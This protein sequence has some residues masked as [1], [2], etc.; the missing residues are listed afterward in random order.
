MHRLLPIGA[1]LA[2]AA[3]TALGATAAATGF[4]AYRSQVNAI[5]RA[6]TPKLKRLESD[7]EAAQ[8]KGDKHR[9]AYDFGAIL[10]LSLRQ[11]VRIENTPVPSDGRARMARPLRL[12]HTADGQLR[13]AITAA[14]SGD[15]NRFTSE[16][17]KLTKI[18]GPLN[19]SFDAVG[20]QDCGSRQT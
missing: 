19:R 14:T 17:T 15:A 8:R 20:L 3:L 6:F 9:Y 2:I 7:M 10:G 5:C 1:L 11:G 16:L 18:T 12:L 13:N 4:S